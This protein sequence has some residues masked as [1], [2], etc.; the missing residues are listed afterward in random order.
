MNLINKI[1]N[2]SGFL[3]SVPTERCIMILYFATEI[4]L[5]WSLFNR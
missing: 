3:D 5:R 2:N 4:K 1:Y